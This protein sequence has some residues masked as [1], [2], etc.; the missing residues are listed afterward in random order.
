[1][2]KP[3]TTGSSASKA[4]L[5]LVAL[6]LIASVLSGCASNRTPYDYSALEASKPASILVL[7]PINHTPDVT[8]SQAVYSNV[9]LPL[10]ESGYYVIPVGVTQT[11]L[12]ENGILNANEARGIGLEKLHA[13]FGADAVLYLDIHR[14]GTVYAVLVSDT[15]VEVEASLVDARTGTPLWQGRASAASS[16]QN[17]SSGSLVGMLVTALVNQVLDSMTERSYAVSSVASNRLLSSGSMRYGALL[18][19]PRAPV[20]KKP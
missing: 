18:P 15:V 2:L 8:A 13:I 17:G 12:Q 1:M 7:P 16:E 10:A 5:G 9:T 3:H 4:K 19:G 14:Y 6:A 20:P 11:V